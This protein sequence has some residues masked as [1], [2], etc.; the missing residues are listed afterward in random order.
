[1]ISILEYPTWIL[2]IHITDNEYRAELS[3]PIDMEFE[4]VTGWK[5]RIF[6]PDPSTG[7]GDRIGDSDS[8]PDE[9]DIDIP[10]RR[11]A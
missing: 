1:M 7:G 2:L 9:G 3:F 5:E 11:K 10:V 8:G 4:Q 6:I